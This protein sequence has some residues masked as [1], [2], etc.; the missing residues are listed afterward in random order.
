MVYTTFAVVA[1][2]LIFFMAMSPINSDI[3]VDTSD[4]VRI[5]EASFYLD[6]VLED[7]ERSS[8][9]AAKRGLTGSANYIIETGEPLEDPEENLT[10]AIVNGSI[11]GVELNSTENASLS[12][13]SDKVEG[14]ARNAGYRLN[15]TV[16]DH[17]FNASGFRLEGSKE[18]KARLKDP[19][20][21]ASFNRTESVDIEVDVD[22]TEDPLLLLRSQGRYT[23][24][25]KYCGFDRPATRIGTGSESSS[26]SVLGEAV[27]EPSDPGGIENKSD[28]VLVVEE[29]ADQIGE[30]DSFAGVVS[31]GSSAPVS[32][33]YVYGT[34]PLSLEDGQD[35]ILSGNEVWKSNF[36]EMIFEDCYV[37]AK[38]PGIMERYGNNLTEVENGILTFVDASSLPSELRYPETSVGYKYFVGDSQGTVHGIDGVTDTHSWFRLDDEDIE[39]WGL[40]GLV[41]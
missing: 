17:E 9:M 35:V 36:R 3:D 18:I 33:D 28:K 14:M 27:V 15:L 22:G 20:T 26:P 16:Q 1:T 7:L 30:A 31:Y 40:E 23:P 38:A 21:L 10:E 8:E 19:V 6:S 41:K 25:I 37:P 4:T 13:W 29:N 34:G 5:S 32:T 24:V 39:R 11:S 2:S 12:E